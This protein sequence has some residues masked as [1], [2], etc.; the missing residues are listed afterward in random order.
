METDLL[1]RLMTGRWAV[2]E[3]AGAW[4]RCFA[5]L[6]EEMWACEGAKGRMTGHQQQR[7]EKAVRAPDIPWPPQ[8]TAA[9]R[10]DTAWIKCHLNA[11]SPSMLG[12]WG[13]SLH[14]SGLQQ[15][16]LYK[17]DKHP[18]LRWLEL[19]ETMCVKCQAQ[20]RCSGKLRS[21]RA[22]EYS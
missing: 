11:T 8:D 5:F 7:A 13:R 15:L 21:P 17:K 12:A 4:I 6:K 22:G 19:N 18:P 10:R 1:W 14:L 2:W 9:G 3:V 20:C 16:P